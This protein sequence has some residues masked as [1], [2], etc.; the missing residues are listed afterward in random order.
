M[1]KNPMSC[2]IPKKVNLKDKGKEG[3]EGIW[4]GPNS[5]PKTPDTGINIM[6]PGSLDCAGD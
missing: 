4:S 2:W 3:G 6:K 5:K 1:L